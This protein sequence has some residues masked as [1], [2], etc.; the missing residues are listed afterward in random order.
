MVMVKSIREHRVALTKEAR[1]GIELPPAL[2]K[3]A[4]D[5]MQS[6]RDATVYEDE[7]LFIIKPIHEDNWEGV[8]IMLITG[9][10][11]YKISK[12]KLDNE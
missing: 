9:Y 8:D 7:E 4:K 3:V 12:V 6:G 1:K 10:L 2:V 11:S 5:V